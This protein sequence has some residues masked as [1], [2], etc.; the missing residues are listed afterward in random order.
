MSVHVSMSGSID[1]T[2]VRASQRGF[3]LIEISI[4]TAIVMLIA[5]VGIPAIQGYVIE[6]KVPRV[7]EEIQRFIARVKANTHGFGATPYSGIDG[8]TL[9]NALRSSG[10]VSVTGQGPG[11]TVALYGSLDAV[12][13][14][15]LTTVAVTTIGALVSLAK[16]ITPGI[17]PRYITAG[18]TAY[19]G[20]GGTTDSVTCS[21]FA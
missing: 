4:V 20:V 10:V 12:Q 16:L 2:A 18:V 13:F 8:G 14:Y 17:K 7:A 11:A 5:I 15:A 21:M 9:A 19:T 1:L 3:S 6:N